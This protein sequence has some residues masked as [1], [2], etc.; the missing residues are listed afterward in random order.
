[1]AK[2]LFL[3]LLVCL[4]G[5]SLSPR[6]LTS[7]DNVAITRVDDSRAV[8]TVIPPKPEPKPVV[9]VAS[10]KTN[11]ATTKPASTVAA[12]AAGV[13]RTP[14]NYSVTVHVGS[15]AEYNNLAYNLSY[16]DIYKY[17]K[18]V[19]GHNSSNL[20]LSLKNRY[21][22]EI[23]TITEGGVKK[24]YRVMW[25]QTMTK[26][27]DISLRGEDGQSYKMNSIVNALGRYDIALMTCSGGANTP[28]R[29]VI[30]ANAV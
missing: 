10:V 5:V 20:L 18:M 2:R 12:P 3:L 19:Y 25:K 17:G 1:M 11:T 29:I 14:V 16:S 6:F 8:E 26:D 24:E 21:V 13:V 7:A 9:K 28:H 22:G 30:F 23:I 27:S 15:R 4:T